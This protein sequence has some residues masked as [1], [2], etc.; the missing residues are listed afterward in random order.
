MCI[1]FR[2]TVPYKIV[3]AS[4]GDAW[5]E[6]NGKVYSPS[7]IG[8]FV[9]MKMKETAESYL[10]SNVKNAVVTVPAYFNDS[11]RQVN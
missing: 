7:Q 6:A 11:Q 5:L 10:G 4:N 1:S 2:K 9:L 3:K 8:A